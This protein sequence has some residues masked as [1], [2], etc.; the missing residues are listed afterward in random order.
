MIVKRE[1]YSQLNKKSIRI[2]T[3]IPVSLPVLSTEPVLRKVVD[4]HF[5]MYGNWFAPSTTQ[6]G[7][8]VLTP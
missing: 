4:S 6:V 2:S 8:L 7:K 3:V 5:S 1:F